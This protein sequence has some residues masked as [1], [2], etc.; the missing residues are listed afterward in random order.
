MP[1]EE[2]GDPD[3]QKR[4]SAVGSGGP[5][6]LGASGGEGDQGGSV[7]G[8]VAKRKAGPKAAANSNPGERRGMC[9]LRLPTGAHGT[10]QGG[11][12]GEPQTGPASLPEG[13]AVSEAEAPQATGKIALQREQAQTTTRPNE[14]WAMDFIHD[15]L[16]NK[17]PVNMFPAV[18]VH[19]RECVALPAGREF[20][21]EDVTEIVSEAGTERAALPEVIS[22]D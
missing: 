20:K 10:S 15:S 19:T 1:S 13:R 12:E 18:D 2:N 16:V 14:R 11:L 21:G 22:V 4:G 7:V 3:A 6:A 9:E 17:Q 5:P 8:A